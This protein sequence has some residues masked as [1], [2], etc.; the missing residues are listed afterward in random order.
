MWKNTH[1]ETKKRTLDLDMIESITCIR[2]FECF[3]LFVVLW[4]CSWAFVFWLRKIMK[5]LKAKPTLLQ[6][7]SNPTYKTNNG[8]KNKHVTIFS[9]ATG[10]PKTSISIQ[11]PPKKNQWTTVTCVEN[12]QTQTL[13]TSIQ[14]NPTP[15]CDFWQTPGVGHWNRAG[16]A[17]QHWTAP[18]VPDLR[19][20]SHETVQVASR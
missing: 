15:T 9:K 19:G 3:I 7:Q 10:C 13:V 20:G 5:K 6:I 4:L 11:P 1:R 8:E 16:V 14:S 18:E 2:F 12:F 17:V